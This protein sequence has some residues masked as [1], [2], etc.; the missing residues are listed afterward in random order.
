MKSKIL[1]I[2]SLLSFFLGLGVLIAIWN[3]KASVNVAWPISGSEVQLS[4]G[5][6]G[7]RAMAG[8][9]GLLLGPILF[10]WGLV[11]LATRSRRRAHTEPLP[12]PRPGSDVKG[13]AASQ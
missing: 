13:Q 11:S 2:F 12:E 5:A 4:G 9:G 10:L 3:G 1:F 6:T 8:L 7:W